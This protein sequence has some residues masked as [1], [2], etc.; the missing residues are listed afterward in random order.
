VGSGYWI[1]DALLDGNTITNAPN[2]P[3][4]VEPRNT[5]NIA[6][7]D[8]SYNGLATSPSNCGGNASAV[9]VIRARP[10][11]PD[12]KRCRFD[13]HSPS[14]RQRHRSATRKA[15]ASSYR[16]D[17]VESTRVQFRRGVKKPRKRTAQQS[18]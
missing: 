11:G 3:V 17:S 5:R 15:R 6:R 14:Q 13:V 10:R 8:N 7:R 12:W 16:P 9:C 18:A 2:G 4:R 1:E